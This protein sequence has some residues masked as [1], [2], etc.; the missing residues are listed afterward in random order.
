MRPFDMR[1]AN[2]ILDGGIS[3]HSASTYF[4][5]VRFSKAGK[6][7]AWSFFGKVTVVGATVE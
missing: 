1:D 3:W 2:N 7:I 4:S 6:T 5:L